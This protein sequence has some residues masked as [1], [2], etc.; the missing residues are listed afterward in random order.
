[1]ARHTHIPAAAS[2][3]FPG[4][5]EVQSDE[6]DES[7]CFPGSQAR[8]ADED[9]GEN[10]PA[11]HDE[12]VVAHPCQHTFRHYIGDRTK[13]PRMM[14]RYLPDIVAQTLVMPQHERKSV[15]FCNTGAKAN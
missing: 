11:S 10:V 4:P 14:R 12:Q 8:Q 13:H 15:G 5:H 2:E 1:M 7:E 6:E 9:A 3:Y